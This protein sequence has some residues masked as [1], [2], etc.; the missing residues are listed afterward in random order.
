MPFYIR[1]SVSVGP[2]RFNLSKSG[3]G[4]SAG[5]KGL[6]FGTGPRGHYVHAGRGGLYYRSTLSN[7]T[8]SGNQTT[9]TVAQP[10]PTRPGP[11]NY[12]EPGVDMIRVSSADVTQMEDSRFSEVLDDLNAKQNSMSMVATLGWTGA[13]ISVVAFFAVGGNGFVGGVVFTLFALLVG[14]WL[15]S[16]QRSSVLMYDLEDEAQSAYEEMTASFDAIMACQGKWHIDAGGAVQDIHAWKRN[17]GAAHLLDKRPTA[18]TYSL[19]RVVKSNITPPSIQSG[20]E[21]LFFLPDFLL[22]VHDKK[23][24]AV[25]Y[26]TLKINWQDSNFIEDG[27][28]PSDTTIIGYNWQHPNKSGGPD[29]RFASNRQIPVCLYDYS[30]DQRQWSE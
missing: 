11:A 15:D 4:V 18:I 20:K 23:V 14:A 25:A 2:F 1:K 28:V 29:L 9:R 8:R 7:N 24:G 12:S 10:T 3:I 16:F 19:P 5:I 27:N 26:D 21:T 17:A 22:V 30:S 13:V 6:R